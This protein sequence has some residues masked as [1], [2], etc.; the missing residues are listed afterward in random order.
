MR[1]PRTKRVLANI[2]ALMVALSV[3]SYINRT[4][5]SIAAP[6]L[7]KRFDLSATQMGSIFSAFL[8]SYAILMPPG[9]WLADRLGPRLVLALTGGG[10]ALFALLTSVVG[11]PIVTQYVSGLWCFLIIRFAMGACSAPLYPA[12]GRMTANWVPIL[13]QARVQGLIIAGAPLGGAITPLLFASLLAR[14]D[15][16]I[17]FL[18]AGTATAALTITWLWYARDQPP[19]KVTFSTARTETPRTRLRAWLTLLRNRNILLLS[20]GYFAINYFEYIFFYWIYYYF[21]EIHKVGLTRSASYTTILLLTM[22]FMMPVGGVVS[23]R[24]IP[25][26]GASSARRVVAVAGMVSGAA[27]L[28]AGT[29]V[30]SELLMLALL[31]LAL[32]L[33]ATAEGPFWAAAIE[34]GGSLAGAAGGIMNGVGNVGGL[35]APFLTPYIAARA[36]WS[37]GLYTGS[38]IVLAGAM[39]W[40]FVGSLPVSSQ[41]LDEANAQ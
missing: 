26:F 2:V 6:A 17:S 13:D 16:R 1:Q 25:H 21:S 22:M 34:M 19:N 30:T 31:S 41:T 32:G 37:W 12:C 8:L 4:I 7:M 27:L 3:M 9:G 39:T 23:D 40:F 36:G 29:R 38:C 5:L 10:T 15:W 18:L 20:S 33:A 11:A 24:L 28:Y 35:L 14:H